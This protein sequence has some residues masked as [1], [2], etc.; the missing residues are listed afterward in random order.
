MRAHLADDD[1]LLELVPIA[2]CY[3]LIDS[4]LLTLGVP[5]E[6]HLAPWAPDGVGPARLGHTD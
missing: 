2:G 5:L 1:A 4:L 6:D 3:R